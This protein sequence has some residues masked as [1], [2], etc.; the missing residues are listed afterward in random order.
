MYPREDRVY[1]DPG[2]KGEE[3]VVAMQLG[4]F[5]VF[6]SI[7]TWVHFAHCQVWTDVLI[8]QC[9]IFGNETLKGVIDLQ[10]KQNEI[11][12]RLHELHRDL[13][14]VKGT[15]NNNQDSLQNFHHELEH[16][17]GAVN[18][19]QDSL[20][21][22]DECAQGKGECS[23]HATCRSSNG[24]YSCSCNPPFEGDGRTCEFSCKSPAEVIEGLGCVK[25]V[26][27]E[28]TW[29]QMNATCQASGWRLLQEFRLEHLEELRR[30]FTYRIITWTGMYEGKWV[31]SG[32]PLEEA[33]WMEGHQSI[34]SNR[35]CGFIKYDS[36]SSLVK[37]TRIDCSNERMGF[38]QFVP[39]P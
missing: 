25:L 32:T 4:A 13:E 24:S 8:T 20:Q 17:K 39:D 22:M 14:H 2:Y 23:P 38:C 9:R 16:V 1:R 12:G 7:V 36:S 31:E 27:E 3:P 15:V 18:N 6:S 34:P 10:Q 28:M 19:N 26:E 35:R 5:F 21:N 30:A 11:L 37:V 29:D 33:L